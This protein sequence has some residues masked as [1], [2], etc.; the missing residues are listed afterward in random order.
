MILPP[1]A[2][3]MMIAVIQVIQM[4]LG[5]AGDIAAPIPEA[6]RRL[7]IELVPADCL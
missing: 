6:R 5:G 4:R 7:R 1:V 2:V 3:V